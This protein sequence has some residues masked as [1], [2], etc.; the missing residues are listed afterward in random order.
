[1]A[2]GWLWTGMMAVV[3]AAVLSVVPQ[4]VFDRFADGSLPVLWHS[5]QKVD[6]VTTMV[7]RL[8][9]LSLKGRLVHAE[10][11]PGAVTLDIMAGRD[12]DPQSVQDVY[13]LAYAFLVDA[14]GVE[15]A[16]VR[17]VDDL[18]RVQRTYAADRS[19]LVHAPLPGT[20]AVPAF[21]QNRFLQQ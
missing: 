7:D 6:S 12:G 11:E 9:R 1:M 8:D 20:D 16:R 3:A 14:S 2:W 21:V 18:G 17:I 4:R 15:H 10:W 13:V 5:P 19:A